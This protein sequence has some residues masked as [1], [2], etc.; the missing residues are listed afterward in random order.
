MQVKSLIFKQVK[1]LI[2]IIASLLC[3]ESFSQK[4]YLQKQ[5]IKSG[6]YAGLCLG[7]TNSFTNELYDG[8]VGIG[9]NLSY[10]HQ[11]NNNVFGIKIFRYDMLVLNIFGGGDHPSTSNSGIDFL[12]GKDILNNAG[13]SLVF[14][15][16]MSINRFVSRGAFLYSNPS[17]NG[18]FLSGSNKYYEKIV[19]INLGLP[20]DITYRF[21][22][23]RDKD[24][25]S[26]INLS[27]NINA[28]KVIT[29]IN[30][31]VDYKFGKNRQPQTS[32]NKS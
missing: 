20:I 24:L 18:G 30:L 13:Q 7:L 6:N 26:I 5:P 15:S 14:S 28:R 9:F 21:N 2:V 29:S 17:G 4:K 31:G 25:I 12:I 19:A 23:F 10:K 3:L 27:N 8:N 1:I 32:T 16:G 22:L 11:L